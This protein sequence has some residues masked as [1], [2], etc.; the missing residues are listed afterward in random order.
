MRRKAGSTACEAGQRAAQQGE[1]RGG[2]REAEEKGM[3]VREVKRRLHVLYGRKEIGKGVQVTQ[4]ES[5]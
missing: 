1:G 5:G 4:W 3:V 2:S